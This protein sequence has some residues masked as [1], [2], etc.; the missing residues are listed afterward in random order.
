[1][2]RENVLLFRNTPMNMGDYM[3]TYLG[4]STVQ[5][6][7]PITYFKIRYERRDPETNELKETFHLY[8][9]AFVNPK[10]Q[11]GLSS[12]PDSRHYLT[13]DLFTYLTVISDPGKETDTS[14]F[15]PVTVEKGDSIFIA[16]GYMVFENIYNEARN[17]NY[18]MKA[19][20]LP[21][22]AVLQVYTLDGHAGTL[23][24]L[25]IINGSRVQHDA[26][27]LRDL[28]L[29]VIVNKILP[30]EGKVEFGVK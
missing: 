5:N 11:E 8:P 6:D 10:G 20:D 17:P 12:N 15:Q 2:S 27:T 19:G 25:Y 26:D 9:D 4:D 1:E 30:E 23:R 22:E 13:K 21:V 24:P 14:S 16:N 29:T 3:V 28:G 7:P 18:E